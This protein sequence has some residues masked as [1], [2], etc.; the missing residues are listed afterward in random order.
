MEFSRQKYWSG[1][2]FP[3]PGDLPNLGIEPRSL[4]LQT[5][6]LPSE[7]WGKPLKSP[8]DKYCVAL[9]VCGHAQSCP[10]LC[11]SKDCSP[12]GSSVHGIFQAR[13]LEWGAISFSRG[14]YR[15]GVK[16]ASLASP[17]LAGEFFTP[18]ATSI[19][20]ETPIFSP[21]PQLLW[22]PG[23]ATVE[24]VFPFSYMKWPGYW[25]NSLDLSYQNLEGLV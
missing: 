1:L 4:A 12:P 18:R 3:S 22:S 20:T 5:D 24:F 25:M 8:W 7:L 11:D 16:P 19:I 13:R 10:A 23:S 17:A 2:P 9:L 6:S 14:S 15:P 21:S